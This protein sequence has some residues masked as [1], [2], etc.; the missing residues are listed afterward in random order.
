[1]TAAGNV[2]ARQDTGARRD[3]LTAALL[4][5]VAVVLLGAPVGL[6]WGLVSPRAALV[7][8]GD[9]LGLADTETKAFIAADGLLFL[10]GAAAGV[11]AAVV[12]HRLVSRRSQRGAAPRTLGVL[13]GLVA[14][15]AAAAYVASRTGLRL[16]DRGAA[17]AVLAAAQAGTPPPPDVTAPLRL[18]AAAALLG[19]PAGAAVAFTLALLLRSAGR[20]RGVAPAGPPSNEPADAPSVASASG[21][22]TAG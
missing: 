20:G 14:G 6:L 16:D 4:T 15:S 21:V 17:R 19:W 18:R 7:P 22:E 12:A 3:E 5:G 13:V 11:L 9:G 2:L 1:M 10:L 8:A